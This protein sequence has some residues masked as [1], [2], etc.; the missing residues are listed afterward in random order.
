MLIILEEEEE[1]L[2]E[3]ATSHSRCVLPFTTLAQSPG[4][5]IVNREF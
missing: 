1:F 5:R 2:E 4:N 3:V